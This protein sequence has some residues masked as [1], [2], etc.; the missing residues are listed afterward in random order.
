[1]MAGW[2]PGARPL[3]SR[4][5]RAS[6]V[7]RAAAGRSS[8]AYRALSPRTGRRTAGTPV[9]ASGLVPDEDR[10]ARLVGRHGKSCCYTAGYP[11]H[12]WYWTRASTGGWG[13]WVITVA[14]P[15][16]AL[17]PTSSRR[18]SR[19]LTRPR[20]VMERRALRNLPVPNDREAGPRPRLAPAAAL[21][22][23]SARQELARPVAPGRSP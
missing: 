1:M 3:G 23:H 14:A 16:P 8:A 22:W 20:D 10:F 6:S 4:P 11:A 9:C 21:G 15:I 18:S 19:H 17:A 13:S 2:V 7:W 5:C 12:C